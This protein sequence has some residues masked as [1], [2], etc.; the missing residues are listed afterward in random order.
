[1][2]IVFSTETEKERE[3]IQLQQTLEAGKICTQRENRLYIFAISLYYNFLFWKTHAQQRF[4][5][6]VHIR[7]HPAQTTQVIAHLIRGNN[8]EIYSTADY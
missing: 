5:N 4:S 7:T 8:P 2:F 6:F 3:K 1:M